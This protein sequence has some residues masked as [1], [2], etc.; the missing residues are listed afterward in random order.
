MKL[1]LIPFNSNGFVIFTQNVSG[2]NVEGTKFEGVFEIG[3]GDRVVKPG[4]G[5]VL[6]TGSERRVVESGFGD[7]LDVGS[8]GKV[9]PSPVNLKIC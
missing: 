5:D 6:E 3:T 7:V 2:A 9:K 1:Q 8:G 4:F